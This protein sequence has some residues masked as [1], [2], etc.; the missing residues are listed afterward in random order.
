MRP[1]AP[2]GSGCLAHLVR[3][4]DLRSPA[5]TFKRIALLFEPAS[6]LITLRSCSLLLPGT[7]HRSPCMVTTSRELHPLADLQIVFCLT[8][9]SLL[10][11]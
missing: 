1:S 2:V 3:L 8:C 11:L 7:L 5:V 10:R 6:L 9:Y 4:A